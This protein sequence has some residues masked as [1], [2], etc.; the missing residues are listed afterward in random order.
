MEIANVVWA[1]LTIL[2][3]VF[4]G[5]MASIFSYRYARAYKLEGEAKALLSE[6][7]SRCNGSNRFI[8]NEEIF[9]GTF[10]EYSNWVRRKVWNRLVITHAIERDPLDSEWS[11]R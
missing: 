6:Y 2:S 3:W 10:P 9:K 8:F 1:V 5:A 11:I 4:L 7:K